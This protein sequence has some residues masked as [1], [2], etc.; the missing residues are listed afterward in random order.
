MSEVQKMLRDNLYTSADEFIELDEAEQALYTLLMENMP[1][2]REWD[3][4][5]P[6]DNPLNRLSN[7][8]QI[9]SHAFRS[10]N[11]NL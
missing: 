10:D 2:E 11:T 6:Y 7:A 4:T 5:E 8:L 9:S 3:R 1:K